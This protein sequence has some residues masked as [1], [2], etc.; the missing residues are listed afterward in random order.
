MH[1]DDNKRLDKSALGTNHRLM[2][3]KRNVS[4]F[5]LLFACVSLIT[6]DVLQPHTFF[7]HV[8]G[9]VMQNVVIPWAPRDPHDV[10]KVKEVE[11]TEVN[12]LEWKVLDRF[13]I[14]ITSL[15]FAKYV[16]LLP[17]CNRV[18]QLSKV[19]MQVFYLCNKC[20]KH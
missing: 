2:N 8:N 7:V 17:D 16:D 12:S 14:N 3:P 6:T 5:M 1:A 9:V 11:G 19:A 10:T 15:F 4:N 18:S 20:L 13:T